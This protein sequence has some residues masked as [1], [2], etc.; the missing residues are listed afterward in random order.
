MN[1]LETIQARIKYSRLFK[2]KKNNVE[3]LYI[4]YGRNDSGIKTSAW[5]EVVNDRLQVFVRVENDRHPNYVDEHKAAI[6]KAEIEK[7]FHELI[8]NCELQRKKMPLHVR[9]KDDVIPVYDTSSKQH[10]I[11]ALRFM[12]SMK[13]SA[14]YADTGTMKS[15][16]VI[17]LVQSRFEAGQIKK[18]LV[19]LPVSTK[20][21]FEE[22]INLW[23]S[24]TGVV[25][26]LIGIESMSSSDK[27]VFDALNFANSETQIIVDESHMVKTPIAKRSKRIKMVCDKSSYKVVM[28]GTPVTENVH[29]LYMQYAMLSELIIGVSNWLK[30][31]EKYLIMGGR[32]GDEIIGYKNLDQLMGLLEPYTYQV[33]KEEVLNLPAKTETS[34]YCSLT[35]EQEAYYY[36]EKDRLL[37][38]I[39]RNEVRATDIFEVF[40]HMQQITSGYYKT[41]DGDIQLL[42][43][44]KL[45]MVQNLDLEQPTVIFCKYIF[46]VDAVVSHFGSENCAVFTGRKPK[47]RDNELQLFR[48]GERHFFVATMQSGGT[49]LNGLQEVSCQAIFYSNSF[50][51]FQRKQSIGRIDRPGQTK[52]TKIIDLLT[53]SGIDT[54]IM[55]NLS[56]KGNLADEIKE[57]MNDK[58]KLKQYVAAL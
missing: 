38:I 15:K 24:T 19:F 53:Y 48:K 34:K 18:A 43:S 11:D 30:F 3:R 25:W 37:E 50:S 49:G 40:T 44:N 56:R 29:N 51:Y 22:Q 7:Q 5:F 41:P 14:L 35:E 55:N 46:E 39:Q 1:T 31:E 33:S 23:S 6:Y 36:A 2:G 54:R 27:A 28:T 47:E 12:C 20:K 32:N 26:K 58:T 9:L 13:V 52:P 45:A 8:N 21:N 10:Q 4:P 17:D 57:M 42:G 16:M